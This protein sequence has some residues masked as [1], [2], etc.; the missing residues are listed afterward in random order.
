MRVIDDPFIIT[1]IPN[2][3]GGCVEYRMQREGIERIDELT[4]EVHEVE[5]IGILL[6]NEWLY[7]N[8]ISHSAFDQVG[9]LD[10]K[11]YYGEHEGKATRLYRD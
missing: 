3:M 10:G 7:N 11:G 5:P 9:Y 1:N 4:N 2:L 8:E 6:L